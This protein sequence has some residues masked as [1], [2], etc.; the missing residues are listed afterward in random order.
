[1][2]EGE[3]PVIDFEVR[4]SRVEKYLRAILRLGGNLPDEALTTRTGAN[5]AVAR[6]LLVVEA[7]RLAT[8]A[9]RIVVGV[10]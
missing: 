9:L 4:L 3:K 6:G 7:R 2:S 5:D 8:E 1:M 10:R